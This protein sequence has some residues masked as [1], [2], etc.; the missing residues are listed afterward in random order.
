VVN[1][2]PPQYLNNVYLGDVMDLLKSLPDGCVDMVYGD[3]DYNV[4]IKYGDKSYT[5]SF[6][7][8]IEWYIELARESLRVLKDDGNMFLINYPKQNA[9]LRV[10]FLDEACYAVHDYVW[11]Y[12][13][14]VGHSPRRGLPLPTEASCTVARVRTTAFTRIRSHNL[15]RTRRTSALNRTSPTARKAE[16]PTAGFISTW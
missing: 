9:Y 15:T 11:I 7:E 14:N 10:K 5:R 8:Y 6:E 2:L 1:E 16:C 12:N 13:T 3:P 4:G